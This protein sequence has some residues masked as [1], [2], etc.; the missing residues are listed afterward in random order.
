MK[1]LNFIFCLS[2]LISCGEKTSLKALKLKE[3][4]VTFS[5][6]FP[7]DNW[8][9]LLDAEGK[10]ILS[11][12][13]LVTAK[14]ITFHSMDSKI[15]WSVDLK[16]LMKSTKERF[17]AYFPVS[18]D[19]IVLL[20]GGTNRIYLIN[21]KA[22]ILKKIDQSNLLLEGMEFGPPIYLEKGQFYYALHHYPL[23]DLKTKN[24]LKAWDAEYLTKSIIA[25]TP[26]NFH[27]EVPVQFGKELLS[28]FNQK[29]ALP[30]EGTYF[31]L[32]QSKLY[33]YSS[34]NDTLYSLTRHQNIPLLKVTSRIGK[35]HITVSTREQY[36]QNT[37]CI[38]ENFIKQSCISDVLH[39]NHRNL[40]YVIIR[41]PKVNEY[42]P[43]NLLVYDQ[44]FKKL[45]EI[46]FD[47]KNHEPQGFTG[48]KGLYL[49]RRFG[50]NSKQKTF[51][52]FVY[53]K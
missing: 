47:G 28:R 50:E 52:L 33:Y 6:T 32:N 41:K 34:Y 37:D 38:N 11:F 29:D 27:G 48:K 4:K 23:T 9:Y 21:R 5:N 7:S 44:H 51:D 53:E 10:E 1:K 35:I 16:P 17:I 45:D 22:K 12:A 14:K 2:L 18:T 40:V 46:E 26:V 8:N 43:F 30:A 24:D 42:F 3:E 19:S 13:D 20:S 49:Q 25:R 15:S 31:H 36:N 39:D